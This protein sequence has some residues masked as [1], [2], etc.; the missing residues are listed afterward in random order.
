MFKNLSVSKKIAAGFLTLALVGAVAG[1]MSAYQTHSALDEVKTANN[2]SDLNVETAELTEKIAAQALSVKSFL[3][4]GNR[5]LLTRS[6]AL[7]DEIQTGFSEVGSL[8]DASLPEFQSHLSELKSSWE[9]WYSQIAAR[10]IELMRTPETVDMARAIDLTPESSGL[11]TAVQQ[12]SRQLAHAVD[13]ERQKSVIAQNTSLNTVQIVS[14][15]STLILTVL[16]MILGFLNHIAISAPLSRLSVITDKLSA[17]DTSQTV[18]ISDRKDEIGLLGRALGV[19]RENLIRTRELEQQAEAERINAERIK[20]EEMEKVASDFEATVLNICD[21][22]I[23][24]LDAL[25]S[26]A[27]SLSTIANNT[28]DQALAVSAAAEQATTNVN[29]VASATEELSASIRAITEQVRSS[30]E[31][32]QEAEHEVGRSNEA[33]ATVQQVVSRIGDVTKLI[34]DI[35]EQTNLLALNATIEAAR[36]GEAGKGFA[37]VA[38]EVKALAEQT[39]KA[40]EEIDRQI[41]EMRQAAD[42]STEATESVAGLVQKISENTHAMSGAAEEQNLAT[43]EI[44]SSVSEA[45]QGTESVS[46]SISEVSGAAS[47]T[48]NLSS[49]MNAAVGELHE[50]SNT[51]RHAMQDFLGKVRAA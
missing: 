40:T 21:G 9:T 51:L 33:V 36:A 19:F 46:R 34:T 27:G 50:Q 24:R 2:L 25:T 48:A 11:L 44:A 29:T 47:E 8:V 28:T 5:D 20:R 31:I 32:A 30:S 15:S 10:Q 16:A 41:T 35:A 49:D 12:Q 42:A 37:V 3:L 43:T 18:D 14:L 17:G 45:A 7:N 39:S 6:Q 38:S 23:T 1:G 4:T 26:S 13:A 22:M